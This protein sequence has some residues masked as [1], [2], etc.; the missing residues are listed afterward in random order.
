MSWRMQEYIW[1]RLSE[2]VSNLAHGAN[3]RLPAQVFVNR[4]YYERSFP[5]GH[6]PVGQAQA[7]AIHAQAEAIYARGARSPFSG[8][9]ED[10][11]FHKIERPN[12]SEDVGV[13]FTALDDDGKQIA[14]WSDRLEGAAERFAGQ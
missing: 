14:D 7:E 11:I 4:K 9:Y 1:W 5:G 8:R 3:G 6:L 12:L 2:R 10:Q 13:R